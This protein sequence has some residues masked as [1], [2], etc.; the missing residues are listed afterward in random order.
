[1][2][3]G[4][5]LVCSNCGHSVTAWDD[6][7]PYYIGA[8]GEK[9]YAYHP[10]PEVELCTGNDASLICLDCG[11]ESRAETPSMRPCLEC[12]SHGLVDV[13]ELNGQICPFCKSST[14][15]EDEDCF[16]VS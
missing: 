15:R 14:F 12:K 16:I 10:S 5:T 8:R 6:G 3:S 1:M 2:A 13:N 9:H 11:C 4:R 7:N